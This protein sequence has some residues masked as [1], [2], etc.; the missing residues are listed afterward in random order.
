VLGDISLLPDYLQQSLA[1]CVLLSRKNSRFVFISHC[2][3][4]TVKDCLQAHLAIVFHRAILNICFSYTST[5]E[6]ERSAVELL[7]GVQRGEILPRS[8]WIWI[9]SLLFIVFL[10]WLTLFHHVFSLSDI[11][12][13]TFARC[14]YTEE[15][16]DPDIL[17][18]T[19]GETRLSDFM[20][21][22]S[23]SHN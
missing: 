20:L 8:V 19:S 12:E 10:F 9:L 11:T 6:F 23:I 5:Q 4:S 3:G 21:F 17:I 22:R 18:R 2:H 15:C 16:P 1:Q 13:D 7:E 14:M